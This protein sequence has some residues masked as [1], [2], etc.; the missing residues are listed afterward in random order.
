MTAMDDLEKERKKK[1][2][3]EAI[4]DLVKIIVILGGIAGFVYLAVNQPSVEVELK[5]RQAKA[6]QWVVNHGISARV[7]CRLRYSD[8]DVIPMDMPTPFVL[9]CDSQLECMLA[10]VGK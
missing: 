8:C 3:Y 5:E 9:R 6:E 7:D 2:R 10:P 4:G 1:L